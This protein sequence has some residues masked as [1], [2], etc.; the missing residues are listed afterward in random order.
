MVVAF[1]AVVAVGIVVF[2]VVAVDMYLLA[3]G[4]A[5]CLLVSGV[6]APILYS[7]VESPLLDSI[8]LVVRLLVGQV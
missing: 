8:L 3:L 2:A 4:V 1:V 7:L 5:S 6:V